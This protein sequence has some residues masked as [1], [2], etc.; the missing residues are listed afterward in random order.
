VAVAML[1]RG[2][3]AGS[4]WFG[5]LLCLAAGFF[6][7]V[8]TLLIK[9]TPLRHEGAE[10]TLL[11]QL[12]VS[13]LVLLG[14]SLA[15]GERGVFAATPL[16]WAALIYQ[17]LIVA[18][19]SYLAWFMLIQRHSA[20]RL[21]AF[22]FLTPLFGVGFA[23]LLLGETLTPSLLAAAALIAGGIYLVNRR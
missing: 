14:G 5:D 16:I 17:T 23:A 10:R 21:S 3:T 4:S 12:W 9:A 7:A 11:W 19:A 8:T 6:W 20:A 2:G 22:T 13:A 15:I 18:S 1:D